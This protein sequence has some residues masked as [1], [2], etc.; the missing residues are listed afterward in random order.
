[1]SPPESFKTELQGCLAGLVSRACDSW[2]RGCEFEPHL[3]CGDYLKKQKYCKKKKNDLQNPEILGTIVLFSIW[4]T[5]K[6][7]GLLVAL[8]KG[9]CIHSKTLHHEN[10]KEFLERC[11]EN[12][13]GQ[14]GLSIL[15]QHLT[16]ALDKGSMVVSSFNFWHL[17]FTM[18]FKGLFL[19]VK[20]RT[21]FD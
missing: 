18:T 17:A 1:V 15:T 7:W 8:P 6:C 5:P 4:F 9:T 11:G 14:R 21:Y 10:L 2:S 3:G 13:F 20:Q 16:L 12:I 19:L